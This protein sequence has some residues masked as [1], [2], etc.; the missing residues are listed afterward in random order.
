MIGDVT[1]R[2]SRCKKPIKDFAPADRETGVTMGY[3]DVRGDSDWAIFAKPGERFICDDCM[4]RHPLYAAR[5]G[6]APA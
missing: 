1:E 6:P 5:Y 3:Y 2:C 4:H